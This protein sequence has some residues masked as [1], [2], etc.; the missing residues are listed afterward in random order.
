MNTLT[1]LATCNCHTIDSQKTDLLMW[2][3]PKQPNTFLLQIANQKFVSILRMDKNGVGYWKFRNFH[4]EV[5]PKE[6]PNSTVSESS[7]INKFNERQA[8]TNESNNSS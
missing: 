2:K 4:E 5:I 1:Q 6:V 8:K 3:L 7:A